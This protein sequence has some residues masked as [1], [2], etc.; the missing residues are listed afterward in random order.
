[1]IRLGHILQNALVGLAYLLI[2]GPTVV[3]VIVSFSAGET[4][5]FPPP[6]LSLRWFVEFFAAD[7]MTGA[8]LFSLRVGATS[9]IAA[10]VLATLAA[11]FVVRQRGAAS[12]ALQS[13]F[14]APLVFPAI[15][16]GLALL[17]F[18]RTINLGGPNG[19]ILAHVL[20]GMPYAF[21]LILAS[22]QNFDLALEEA[23]QSLGAGP[24]RTFFL[25]TLPIIWPGILSGG[26]FAFI[27]SFGELN[28][29]LF[30]T[31]PG[32]T[33]L[34]IEIFGYLQ[35]PGRQ[36]I[37]AAASTMQVALIVVLALTI[38]RL[39]GLAGVGRS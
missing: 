35:F 31:G 4:F 14:T 19:L 26:L 5:A 17:L 15:I 33:T 25:V 29:A 10:T 34:P 38:E 11:R 18:Y 7:N 9:A 22:L 24:I 27:V 8:F 1:M 13:L 21:R 28:V 16:L 3:V 32:F 39:V 36:L 2:L 30:L 23:A 6:G 37:I 12:G 20:I